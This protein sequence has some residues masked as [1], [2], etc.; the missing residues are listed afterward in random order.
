[1]IGAL[2]GRKIKRI[3]FIQPPAFSWR[4]NRLDI[5]P[6][7]PLGAA[8]IAAVLE[9]EGYEVGILDA[10]VEGWFR[11]PVPL[12]DDPQNVPY[13]AI[14]RVGL[15]FKEIAQRIEAF[16]PDVLGVTNLFTCQRK[17][18]HAVCRIAKEIDRGMIVVI[19]GKNPTA[20]TD[21]TMQDPNI[22]FAIRGEGE[23]TM[24]HLLRAIEKGADFA[25]IDG[26]AYRESDGTLRVNS[27][28]QFIDDLD[29]IPFPARHLLPMQL[30]FD[31]AI[32]HGGNLINRRYA[33]VI[34]S[35]GC[36]A[37]CFFCSAHG[38]MGY[39]FRYR[40]VENVL[41][42]IDELVKT[43]QIGEILFED[44]NL[45]M[46]RERAK[47]LCNA[48][49]E[50]KYNL[51]WDT[52][53]GLMAI[54][55]DNELLLKMKQ[56]GCY[57]VNLAI[58]SG[59]Q[60]VVNNVIR[61]PLDLKKVPP[62]I[63]YARS[64][65]LEVGLFLVIGNPGETLDQMRESYRF[66]RQNKTFPH[67][68]VAMPLPGTELLEI[69]SKNGYLVEGFS[70]ENLTI[71]QFSMHT[72]DWS[73]EELKALKALEEFKLRLFNAPQFIGKVF[74]ALVKRPA[75]TLSTIAVTLTKSSKRDTYS[76]LNFR[77]IW[78]GLK[79]EVRDWLKQMKTSQPSEQLPDRA[80][81]LKDS[82][83]IQFPQWDEHSGKEDSHAANASIPLI[84]PDE[85]AW[86]LR[87]SRKAAVSE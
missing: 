29:S 33:S 52:P 42:E 70:W 1:M 17:N 80:R 69:A 61:K 34:T 53:N 19:G 78:K 83:L 77:W 21:V 32:A 38:S 13:D 27:K 10:F 26:I 16:K 87:R 72:P 67:V 73:V 22:D 28:T 58:E 48:L 7:P 75:D 25:S 31:A 63:D 5:N 35:R 20:L 85:H 14:E 74:R 45:T 86:T 40:S 49:I 57:R 30:Y 56:S 46:H 4:L 79:Y 55:L 82:A 18:A 3:L 8:Y 64:I 50:R 54:T 6:N 81:V 66:A 2:A 15:T 36:P 47:K 62:M 12:E 59:N 41:A 24:L 60:H 9:R 84:L 43:Y 11:E 39:K 71:N 76:Y 37:E 68:S 44:D 65:G 51:T 23:A